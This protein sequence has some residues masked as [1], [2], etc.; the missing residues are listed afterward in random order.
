LPSSWD[1]Y[2]PT[3]WDVSTLLGSFGLFFT[4]FLLFVRFVPQVAMAE[5]KTILPE[6]DPHRPPRS[7]AR[8]DFET[9]PLPKND[10]PA[11]QEEL[12]DA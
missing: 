9:D 7:P 4:L 5:V 10:P 11:G 8:G 1:Y 6:A 2:S 3:F 12:D